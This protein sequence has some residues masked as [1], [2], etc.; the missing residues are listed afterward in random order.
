MANAKIDDYG[1]ALASA[2]P[3][4][5]G[6][7]IKTAMYAKDGYKTKAG[8]KIMLAEDIDTWDLV[9]NSMG[10]SSADIAREREAIWMA[11]SLKDASAP[12]R[13]RFYRKEQ[14]LRGDLIRA[15]ASGDEEK[16]KNAR[17]RLKDLYFDLYVLAYYVRFSG[18]PGMLSLGSLLVMSV[19][20]LRIAEGL[21]VTS[22]SMLSCSVS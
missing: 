18:V 6:A 8:E 2:L 16:I 9:V 5:I 10:F 22:P 14:K 21:V 4:I 12:T 13:R 19:P 7:P 17:E 20:C 1:L 3:K 15:V 11:K